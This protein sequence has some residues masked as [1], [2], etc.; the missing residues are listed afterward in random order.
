MIRAGV[1]IILSF[2]GCFIL[3]ESAQ[4]QSASRDS[5][6][7]NQLAYA[8]MLPPPDISTER[9]N[10]LTLFIAER[11][12]ES[13]LRYETVCKDKRATSEDF[14][15]LGE[16]YF[17]NGA[18]KVAAQN[19]VQATHLEPQNDLA[20]QR[21]VESLCASHDKAQAK[22]SCQQSLAVLRDPIA[23]QQMQNLLRSIEGQDLSTT[24]P[25]S[26]GVMGKG[27]QG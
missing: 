10:A 27:P 7:R 3:N 2:T 17:R 8:T 11:F 15:H 9:Q 14:C 4:A 22:T 12:N 18:Y 6:A 16:C 26:T 19:F 24:K 13:A 23:R 5:G 21:L 25:K 1:G 20:H